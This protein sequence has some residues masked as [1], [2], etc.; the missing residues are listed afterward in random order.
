MPTTSSSSSSAMPVRPVSKTAAA[1]PHSPDR[2]RT[3]MPSIA[4]ATDAQPPGRSHRASSS[5]ASAAHSPTTPAASGGRQDPGLGLGFSSQGSAN[6][7]GVHSAASPSPGAHSPPAG[8]RV[9]SAHSLA[10]SSDAGA[11][12][13]ATESSIFERDIEHRDARHV[14]SKSEAVDVAIPPV[15]DDAVEAIIESSDASFEIVEPIQAASPAPAALSAMALTVHSLASSSQ[16]H[17]A[18]PITESSPPMSH[19]GPVLPSPVESPPPGSIAAQIAEKLSPAR[20]LDDG[21]ASTHQPDGISRHRAT[22]SSS[23]SSVS[24]SMRSRSVGN[25]ATI[26]VQQVL[27]GSGILSGSSAGP[28]SPA[29]A[30]QPRDGPFGAASQVGRGYPSSNASTTPSRPASQ[31]FGTAL[32]SLPLPNPFRSDGASVLRHSPS[33]SMSSSSE[34]QGPAGPMSMSLDGAVIPS[35]ESAIRELSL[36]GMADALAESSGVD[37]NERADMPSPILPRRSPNPASS[38]TSHFGSSPASASGPFALSIFGRRDTD[39]TITPA[40]T[41]SDPLKGAN[42]LPDVTENIPGGLPADDTSSRISA[43]HSRGT[44]ASSPSAR[45]LSFFSYADIINET[46]AEVID[47]ESAIQKKTAEDVTA[48]VKASG[49]PSTHRPILS[50]V[51][52]VFN[53]ASGGSKQLSPKSAGTTSSRAGQESSPEL[54]SNRYTGSAA[55]VTMARSASAGPSSK[56]VK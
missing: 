53:P 43:T 5:I 46:P 37:A 20:P 33:A 19:T 50:S 30:S 25:A 56:S 41:A 15:L 42:M 23:A 13:A 7:A 16:A 49:G 34:A 10:P 2:Q 45:R 21:L 14:L 32:P 3:I 39:A 27:D 54:K 48:T 52:D 4:D 9:I 38:T 55:A 24:S 1:R 28:G 51:A 40:S 36:D 29:R 47:L 11:S 18:S 44:S 8:S 35:A 31:H 17:G 26:G 22:H 12:A 6:I